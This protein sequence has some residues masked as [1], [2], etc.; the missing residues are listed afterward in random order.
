[1][2]KSPRLEFGFAH[3]ESAGPAMVLVGDGSVSAKNL[4]IKSQSAGIISVPA[5]SAIPVELVQALKAEAER[6]ASVSDLPPSLLTQF[7]GRGIDL[8]DWVGRGL[9]L[10]Q[11]CEHLLS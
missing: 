2:S 9:T 7:A 6:G 11:I 5:H 10:L 3:I 1:M 4:T 8:V